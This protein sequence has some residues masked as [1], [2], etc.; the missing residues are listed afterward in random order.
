MGP[1]DIEGL[2]EQW[3]GITEEELDFDGE[4]I[5]DLTGFGDG[6]DPWDD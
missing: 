5:R 6:Q 3:D 2:E 4:D 1:D